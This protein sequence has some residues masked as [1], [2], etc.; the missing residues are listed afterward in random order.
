VQEHDGHCF[1]TAIAQ[2]Q[3]TPAHRVFVQ[4][5]QLDRGRTGLLAAGAA[6]LT[7]A[8]VAGIFSG[9]AGGTPALPST[10]SAEIRSP[11]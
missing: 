8:A 3:R 4:R 5:L 1:D 11:F 2:R 9:D 7:L 6:V 10:P